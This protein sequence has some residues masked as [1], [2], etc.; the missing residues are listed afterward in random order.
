MSKL[1]WQDLTIDELKDLI[2]Y[3]N[4]SSYEMSAYSFMYGDNILIENK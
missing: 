3:S 2:T 1:T 4:L